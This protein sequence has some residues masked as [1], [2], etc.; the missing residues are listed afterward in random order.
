MC[1]WVSDKK[2]RH[3]GGAERVSW[4]AEPFRNMI[5]AKEQMLSLTYFAWNEH[6]YMDKERENMRMNEYESGSNS[7]TQKRSSSGII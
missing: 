1:H 2:L 5:V 7:A 4:T 6:T 3:A